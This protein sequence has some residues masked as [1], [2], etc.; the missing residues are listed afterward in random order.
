MG[1]VGEFEG[2]FWARLPRREGERKAGERR[3]NER[4][5]KGIG[6]IMLAAH[7]WG[8]ESFPTN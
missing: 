4:K 1:G 5:R 6:K 2:P 8:A 7:F 3:E